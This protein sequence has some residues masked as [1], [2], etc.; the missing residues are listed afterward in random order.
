[1]PIEPVI[2]KLRQEDLKFEVNLEY[3]EKPS[4]K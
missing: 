2:E 1:M 4:R 3:K